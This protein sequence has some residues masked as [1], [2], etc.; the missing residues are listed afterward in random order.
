MKKTTLK[1]KAFKYIILFT[2]TFI[3]LP[4]HAACSFLSGAKT[5]SI[6]IQMPD[7]VVQR[8]T[9]VGTVLA[10]K[11]LDVATH[12]AAVGTAGNFLKCESGDRVKYGDSN[13]SAVNY[14]GIAMLDSGIQG[15]SIRLKPYSGDQ[16]FQ[17]AY[18]P[19]TVNPFSGTI[20][21]NNYGG[22]RVELVK[23]GPTTGN[24]V[25]KSGALVRAS[26]ENQFYIF[27]Y[28]MI[29]SKVTTVACSVTTPSVQVKFGNVLKSKFTGG[30]GSSPISKDFNITMNCDNFARV[31]FSMD[32]IKNN[33]VSDGS[34]LALT[35]QGND[36]VASGVGVQLSYNETPLILNKNTVLKEAGSGLE[37]FKFK[38]KYYQTKPNV[39]A[40]SANAI[41]TF[42][43]TYQ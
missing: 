16:K 29:A 5:G 26:A 33:D 22:L 28:Q 40:G 6:N 31:N 2:A 14:N 42:N 23:T 7:L 13:F 34:V 41:A 9:P 18:P 21:T 32:G 39:T 1:K 4:A 11:A 27:N 17:W 25:I 38:A 3:E 12:S 43:I 8:D 36:G 30:I 37:N 24:G 19:T 35:G 10:M 20:T 15:I